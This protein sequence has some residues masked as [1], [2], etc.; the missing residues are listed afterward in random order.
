[1]KNLSKIAS[2]VQEEHKEFGFSAPTETELSKL[3]NGSI[4]KIKVSGENFWTVISQITKE[5][6]ITATI[7]N[8]LLRPEKHGLK[9][10]DQVVFHLNN[11]WE[12]KP[13]K[14]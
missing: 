3:D 13:S 14:L 9:Y 7:V 1:M 11:I 6:E 2:N 12:I 5:G 10:Q 4:V 8:E